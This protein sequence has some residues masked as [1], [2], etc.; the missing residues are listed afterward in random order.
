MKNVGI[1]SAILCLFA[2]CS[3]NTTKISIAHRGASGYLPEHTL[4]GVAMAHGQNVDFIEPD[5]VLTKDNVPI[6]LHDIHLDSTTNV[7]EKFPDKSRDDGKWYAIDFTIK[8][9]K[10]L[11]IH[12]RQNVSTEKNI[13]EKRFNNKNIKFNIPT[14]QE[15]IELVQELNKTTGKKIG[16]YPEI[17][18][19]EFHNN[20]K[21]DITKIVI[22]MLRKYKYEDN[23]DQIYIQCFSADTLIRLRDDFK[24]KIPLIQ[25]IAEN[26]WKLSNTDYDKMITDKGI[27]EVSKYAVGIG[28]WIN[29][30]FEQDSDGK[31]KKKKLLELA[32]LYK[33]KIHP[34][35]ARKDSLP[36]NVK[37]FKELL[38]ILFKK[39][40]VDGV[41]SDFA[42]D[43]KKYI[44]TYHN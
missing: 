39:L 9:I 31:T 25:L 43:V 36:Q 8:E 19:P 32:K 17:K 1:L 21:K 23:P 6:V 34:Y 16:I 26:N 7:K 42:V 33:L 30:L 29:Q 11:N 20:E 44:E 41:F 37:N 15:Y 38:D 14:L 3:T 24:T 13:F 35:T 22:S 27:S 12:E 2:S 18:R 5:I 28:P 4:M 40:K 10:S